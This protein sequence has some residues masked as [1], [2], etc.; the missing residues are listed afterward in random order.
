MPWAGG[1]GH[2]SSV[3]ITILRITILVEG[4]VYGAVCLPEARR[5]GGLVLGRG[6]GVPG[7]A[8]KVLQQLPVLLQQL[9]MGLLAKEEQR[10]GQER[11]G[12]EEG[13]EPVQGEGG[14]EGEGR[15]EAVQRGPGRGQAE[16]QVVGRKVRGAARRGGQ[17]L[18]LRARLGRR[19]A[20][21]LVRALTR[22]GG[23]GALCRRGDV[24]RRGGPR[25][26][27]LLDDEALVLLLLGGGRERRLQEGRDRRRRR[28]RRRRR[29]LLVVVPRLG[30]GPEHVHDVG[31]AAAE[32]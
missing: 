18:G 22:L 10:V 17:Y 19:H 7:G 8:A 25:V 20:V 9:Q 6:G 3:L 26:G 2:C 32:G 13:A 16:P 4:E 28:R 27:Q 30:A 23:V 21:Q 1:R 12:G 31:G 15:L 24:Q 5:G 14:G 29:W 11:V